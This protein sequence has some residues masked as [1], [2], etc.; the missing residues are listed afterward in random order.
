MPRTWIPVLD[1]VVRACTAL[2]RPDLAGQLVARREALLDPAVRVLVVGDPGQGKSALVN[3]LVDAPVC[4]VGDGVTTAMATFVRYAPTPTAT[5]LS[6]PTPR[7]ELTPL[8]AAPLSVE[9]VRAKATQPAATGTR[10]QIG[11]PRDLL[12]AGL[13]LIDCPADPANTTA[14]L[15]EADAVLLI[16]DA[17]RELSPGQLA[18]LERMAAR[19]V[20]VVLTKIDIAPRWRDALA[21]TQGRIAGAGLRAPV[22]PVSASLRLTAVRAG[23]QRLHEESGVSDLE[24]F[25]G[26]IARQRDQLAARST[27]A[28]T[29]DVVH[30]LIGGIR[31]EQARR[32]DPL[33]GPEHS[34]WQATQERLVQLQRMAAR[35]PIVL[36]DDVADLQSDVEFDVRD[37]TRA[38][39]REIDTYFDS[40]DPRG[41]W[42]AFEDWLRDTLDEV[43]ETNF[44]WQIERFAWLADKIARQLSLDDA[45]DLAEAMEQELS[46][47]IGELAPPRTEKFGPF[48]K[49]FS[50]LRGSYGGLLMF[51]LATTFAG[52]PLVN[53]ISVSAGAVF[54]ART[55]YEESGTRKTRRQATAK[56]V[57]QRYVDDFFLAYSKE[58]RDAARAAH[59]LVRDHFSAVAERL[60]HA[61]TTAAEQARQELVARTTQRQRKQ[62]EMDA[63]LG[64]LTALAEQLGEPA[65]A[66]QGITA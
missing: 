52:M 60:Q 6:L 37:R 22:I 42:D 9:Q 33:S 20:A 41:D 14:L 55:V 63:L 30:T 25:L 38:I 17:T 43:A 44:T 59:R 57:A 49:L 39:V 18:M 8:D 53:P 21:D 65:R 51:G 50:G 10:A 58:S 4:A 45:G 16:C 29:T 5:V 27:S 36:A 47:R 19:P 48:Q 32:A 34:R 1:S 12:A 35:W 15:P 62:A 56:Q 24:L 23:D 26:E 66:V 2:D 64:Q 28:L 31:A 3:A 7:R 11:L 40:A 61:A 54:G 13:V 46:H